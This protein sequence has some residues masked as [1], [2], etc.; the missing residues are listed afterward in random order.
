MV[1]DMTSAADYTLSGP[2]DQQ[3]QMQMQDQQVLNNELTQG[4]RA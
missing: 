4:K 1:S 3:R 2:N